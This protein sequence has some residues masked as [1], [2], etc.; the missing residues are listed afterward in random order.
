MDEILKNLEV[1]G[2][3]QYESKVFC[4]LFEGNLCTAT[5]IANKAGIPRSSSYDILKIFTQKG[6][7]NEIQ[8]SSVAKY[9]MIDPRV[10]QDKIERQIKDAY[11]TKSEKLKDSFEKLTPLFK[12][13]ELEND[14]VDV[15]LI[16]GYNKHRYAKFMQLF[17]DSNEELLLMNKL[18]GK[19]DTELDEVTKKFL[20]C[21]G[22]F[23]SIYEASYDFKIKENG[24]WKNIT[25]EKIPDF[26]G[27]MASDGSEIRLTDKI[28]QNMAVFDRK[29]VFI[30][31]VDPTI[32]QYNRSDMIIKN[33]NFAESMVEFFNQAWDKA[34]TAKDFI[35]KISKEK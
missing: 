7:C 3:T 2:F 10:V 24:I 18:E 30:S 32:S 25:P 21:G 15:E 17:E 27:E 33:K 22:I 35:Q 14:K 19:V 6:I 31:L 28:Y 11:I 5:E 34:Y 26:M 8:T 4:V 16:K 29:V 13:K 1:L 23:R 20:K 12:A 9:E